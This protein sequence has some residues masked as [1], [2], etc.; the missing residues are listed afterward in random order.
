MSTKETL[1]LEGVENTKRFLQS[2]GRF[3]KTPLLYAMYGSGDLA[4]AF[5]R[6]FFINPWI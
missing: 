1:C 5:C 6:Y 2:L 3:G 4:Q